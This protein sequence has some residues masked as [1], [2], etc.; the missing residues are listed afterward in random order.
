[1]PDVA[2]AY[3]AKLDSFRAVVGG[4][5]PIALPTTASTLTTVP[6]V[7]EQN[8]VL[9]FAYSL[10]LA[11]RSRDSVAILDWGGGIGLYFLLARAFLPDAVSVG[12]HCKELPG[13][14]A[15]GREFMPE[16]RFHEDDSCLDRTYDVVLAC[17]SLQYAE[18]WQTLLSRLA[19]AASSYLLVGIPVVLSSPSFVVVQRPPGFGPRTEYLS[20]V[21]NRHEFLECSRRSALE[22]EREFLL[23]FKP[24]IDGAPERAETR[25]FL[26]RPRR[27]AH[28]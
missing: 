11:A 3:K 10:M 4:S 27:A 18:D 16:V 14:C 23:G 13:V 15:A 5:G 8:T 9:V 28:G 6:S 19:G 26:F 1:V 12:Y 21:F 20:W 24:S 2:D 17:S 7:I 25:A 22:L